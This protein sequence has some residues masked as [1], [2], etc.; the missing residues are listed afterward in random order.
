MIRLWVSGLINARSVQFF[1]S[2]AGVALTV[3]ILATIGSFVSRSAADMTVRAIAGVPVDWQIAVLPGVDPASMEQAARDTV[4]LASVDRVQYAD[5][6]A[7]EATA[8][9]TVQTTGSGKVLGIP[10]GY[11]DR[12]PGQFRL[13]LGQM[14]DVLLAQQTAANLH[15][16][17]GDTIRI[18]LS[19]GSTTMVKV[20]GIV[21]LPDAD[22]MFQAIGAPPGSAPQAPPDNV[23]ILSLDAWHQVFGALTDSK[24]GSIQSQLHAKL[25]RQTLPSDPVA[26]HLEA[27][28][29][30]RHFGVRT[31]GSALLANNLAARLEAVREDALYARLLF[32][33]LALPG[34]LLAAL[35]TVILARATTEHR[36]RDQ[37]LLRVCGV[38]LV[39]IVLLSAA[40]AL[41]EGL[42]GA[43][44]GL[45]VAELISR[46][47][48][49]AS[50]FVIGAVW[51]SLLS[52]VLGLLLAFFAVLLPAWRNARLLPVRA[53][54]NIDRGPES[55]LWQRIWLDV[56]FILIGA[57][58]YW[59][60][61]ATGYQVV[62]APEGVAAT[63]VDYSAFLAP[64]LIAAGLG[65]AT[66]RF[67][68]WAIA[69]GRYA[70]ARVLRPIAGALSETV[71]ATLVRQS[72]R[73]TIGVATTALA[74]AFAAS[75]AIFNAT[76]QAQARVDA[77]LT[78]GSDVTVAGSIE[79]PV[80]RFLDQLSKVPGLAAA[81]PMQH[82]YAYV[83]SDLQD[84]YGIDAGHISRA[85][86]LS[87]AYFANGDAKAALADLA[88]TKNGVF[89]SQETVNDYQL[90]KGDTINLRLQF[91]SDHQYHS[92]PFT[93]VGVVREF[94]TA[95]E[96]LLRGSQPQ[97]HHGNDGCT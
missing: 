27:E 62:L 36:R 68:N 32:L 63:A 84:L 33:F 16:G 69:H 52:A 43:T 28:Q 4:Q 77:E 76:Y 39:Q 12:Y 38:S 8:G 57:G 54:A 64:L 86:T 79:H 11:P 90:A 49:G 95:P 78:N 9:G 73:I 22:A 10:A 40:E 5:V 20:S 61:A 23:L 56:L 50:I 2:I 66:L 53:E 37:F 15:V 25:V 7:F 65:L 24:P 67:V 60:S 82:R 83:G 21:E 26:A 51:W 48:F 71:A 13:L 19:D 46:A 75:T 80:S 87:N 92:V 74:F 91:A 89:V 94:P 96:G 97:L 85:T 59:R 31:T 14:G 58:F 81:E 42:A 88:T 6:Q 44:A 35:L 70:A 72:R 93:I 47:L 30:G 3:A 45:L 1:G 55:P 29:L 18:L 34:A 41:L 17:P